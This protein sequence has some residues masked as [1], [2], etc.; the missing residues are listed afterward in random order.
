MFGSD[1]PVLNRAGDHTTWTAI[2]DR[3]AGVRGDAARAAVMG[4]T[5][6]RFYLEDDA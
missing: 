6:R 5:A 1:W 3:A 2:A 4:G